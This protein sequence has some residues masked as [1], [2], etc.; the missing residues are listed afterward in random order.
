MECIQ[1]TLEDER[2]NDSPSSNAHF[3]CR[4][5]FAMQPHHHGESTSFEEVFF[6]ELRTSAQSDYEF[7]LFHIKTHNEPHFRSLF[8]R[9]LCRIP[10]PA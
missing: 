10:E 4:L 6:K 5:F 2:E 7:P 8:V 9:L 3:F 1:D